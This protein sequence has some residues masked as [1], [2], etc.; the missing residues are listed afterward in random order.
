M[1][2]SQRRTRKARIEIIPMI[3]TMFFLLIFFMLT[4]L[5][6]TNL[7]SV[8]V[9][10]PKAKGVPDKPPQIVT[11]TITKNGKLFLNKDECPSTGEAVL[12]IIQKKEQDASLAVIINADRN[13]KHGRVVELLDAVQQSGVSKVAIAVKRGEN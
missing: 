13:V 11:L 6:M 1:R 5:S 7:Y 4:S 8:P 10:L 3:D 9:N 12:R 2:L